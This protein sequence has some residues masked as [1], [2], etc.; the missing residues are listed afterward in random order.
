[1]ICDRKF[2]IQKQHKKFIVESAGRDEVVTE[3]QDQISKRTNTITQIQSEITELKE[4]S[5]GKKANKDLEM[6]IKIEQ[7]EIALQELNG[8]DE[9]LSLK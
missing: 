9:I 8:I 3:F 5:I 1:M 7:I 4:E 2:L 6:K